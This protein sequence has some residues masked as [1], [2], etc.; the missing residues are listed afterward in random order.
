MLIDPFDCNFFSRVF[1]VLDSSDNAQNVFKESFLFSRQEMLREYKNYSLN[2]VCWA[3]G[4][5]IRIFLIH[6]K[7]SEC[8]VD[9]LPFIRAL[10]LQQSTDFEETRKDETSGLL[11]LGLM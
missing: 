9:D 11:L 1:G 10:D 8:L 2:V 5:N 3:I 4:E 6:N 7:G